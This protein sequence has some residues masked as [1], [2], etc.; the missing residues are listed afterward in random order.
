MEYPGAIT[1]TVDSTMLSWNFCS[2][3]TSDQEPIL[4]PRVETVEPDTFADGAQEEVGGEKEAVGEE[5]KVV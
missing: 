4:P 3:Y 1:P 5:K 2:K